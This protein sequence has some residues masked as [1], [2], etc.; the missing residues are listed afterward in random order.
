MAEP[1]ATL[2]QAFPVA[3]A[4]TAGMAV[5]MG[6]VGGVQ[7]LHIV[8]G[9]MGGVAGLYFIPPTGIWR[10]WLTVV[11]GASLAS[12][13]GPFVGL[14]VAHYLETPEGITS[15][16]MALL[17]ALF[18]ADLLNGGR[19]LLKVLPAYLY[20]KFTGKALAPATCSTCEHRK[21]WAEPDGAEY[22]TCKLRRPMK[23]GCVRYRPV[24]V[25]GEDEQ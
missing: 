15:N 11:A 3:G 21:T 4:A 7:Y 5:A 19:G 6:D 12:F 20:E 16:F 9:I 14:L 22:N 24:R 10:G 23:D 13:G 17:L 18:A 25:A 8:A 2:S 1:A